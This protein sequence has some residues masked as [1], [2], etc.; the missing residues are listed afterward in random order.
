MIRHRS[1]NGWNTTDRVAH[2]GT[3]NANPLSA[4]AGFTCLE[5]IATE[6]IVER[7]HDAAST[8]KSELNRVLCTEGVSGL[9]HGH[10][11]DMFLVFDV[12][13]DGDLGEQCTVPHDAVLKSIGSQKK[14]MFRKAM[15]NHGV[16]VMNGYWLVCSSVL[17]T[18]EINHIVDAF[19]RSIR[20]MKADDLF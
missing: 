7:T 18:T 15:L 17:G 13:Y 1:D 5:M 10:G 2:P 12:D 16:D 8:I 19:E 4:T 20:D 9:V 14:N 11:S 3:F 6:P